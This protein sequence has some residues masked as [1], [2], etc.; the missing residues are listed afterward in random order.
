MQTRRRKLGPII[1]RGYRCE[2]GL[3]GRDAV[4]FVK[5]RIHARS[6]TMADIYASNEMDEHS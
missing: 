5:N 1:E 2:I 3:N 4:R 6:V